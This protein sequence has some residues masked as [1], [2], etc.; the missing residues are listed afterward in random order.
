M[1]LKTT[2]Q[3]AAATAFNVVDS[4]QVTV[5]IRHKTGEAFDPATMV[6]APTY[7]D[8]I[9]SAI[10]TNF[11]NREVDGST[12]LAGDRKVILQYSL[13]ALV[14]PSDKVV[15]DNLTYDIVNIMRDPAEATWMLQVR[16]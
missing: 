4:L 13:V 8:T 12:V 9:V 7:T 11:N 14:N 10:L 6:N 3:Q 15:I 5:T 16:R 2:I 1:S